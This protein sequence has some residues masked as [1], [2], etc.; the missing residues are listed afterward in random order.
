VPKV[1][2]YIRNDDYALW[3]AVE[4]KTEFLHNALNPVSI[5]EEDSYSHKQLQSLLDKNLI[6][7][8]AYALIH[9]TE[10]GFLDAEVR[11]TKFAKEYRP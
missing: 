11:A 9:Y 2:V 7:P 4:K 8:Y 6:T 3:K 5:P 10:L 1:T